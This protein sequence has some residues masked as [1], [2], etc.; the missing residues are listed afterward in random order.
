M[1]IHPADIDISRNGGNF[2]I[3]EMGRLRPLTRARKY[4]PNEMYSSRRKVR[5][6]RPRSARPGGE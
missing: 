6:Q 2:R 5:A 3:W 1:E 4:A